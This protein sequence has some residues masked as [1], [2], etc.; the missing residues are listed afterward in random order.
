MRLHVLYSYFKMGSTL[1]WV[2][3]STHLKYH[4]IN[5]AE[6]PKRKERANDRKKVERSTDMGRINDPVSCVT[7]NTSNTVHV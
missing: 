3:G 5:S 4:E 2:K 1:K 7:D 6:Q